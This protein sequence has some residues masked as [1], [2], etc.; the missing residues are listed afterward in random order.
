[1]C[2]HLIFFNCGHGELVM[3]SPKFVS[4][5][6]LLDVPKHKLFRN[7][8]IR[9]CTLLAMLIYLTKRSFFTPFVASSEGKIDEY[10][11]CVNIHSSFDPEKI[12]TRD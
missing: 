4:K 2:I 3:Q 11:L 7:A 1:M 10:T 5:L 6:V 12:D 8:E 9:Y